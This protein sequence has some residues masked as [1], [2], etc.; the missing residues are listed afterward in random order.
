MQKTQKTDSEKFS[1]VCQDRA[2]AYNLVQE[3]IPATA[4]ECSNFVDF[5]CF[6]YVVVLWFVS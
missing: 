3:I 2:L 4:P 5:V 6:T 1:G